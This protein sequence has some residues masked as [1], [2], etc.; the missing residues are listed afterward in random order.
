MTLVLYRPGRP[1]RRLGNGMMICDWRFEAG[2]KQGA[3]STNTVHGDL[4]P[5]YELRDT[6]TGRLIAKVTGHLNSEIT[7]MGYKAEIVGTEHSENLK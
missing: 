7:S 2:G 4:V 6:Y 5:Q 1:L 3:F